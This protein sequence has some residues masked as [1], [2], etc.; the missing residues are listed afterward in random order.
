MF[1]GKQLTED[2]K[3]LTEVGISADKKITIDYEINPNPE[4]EPVPALP[5]PTTPPEDSFIYA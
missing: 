3:I 4:P 2:A 5:P 1:K